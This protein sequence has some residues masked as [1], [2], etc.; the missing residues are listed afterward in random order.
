MSTPNIRFYSVE[1]ASLAC[2]A[3]ALFLAAGCPG[4]PD[5]VPCDTEAPGVL[6][7]IAGSGEN[8]HDHD[9]DT[10]ILPAL[11]ARFSLPQDTL[12][13][14][15][16]VL[17]ILDWNNHRLRALDPNGTIRW[18][19]GRGELGGS[20][21]D[22]ENGDFNHPTNIIFNQTG[23]RIIMAAWHNSKIREIDVAT[24]EIVDSC[25]DGKRA[26]FGDGGPALTASLD[27]PTSIALDPTGNLVI[28]DQANQVIRRIESDGS[29]QRIA[30]QCIVDS[31]P[32]RGPGRC[33]DG[34]APTQCPDGPNGPSGKFTCGDPA[35]FCGLPCTPGYSGDGML[36][37]EMRMNQPFGQSATPAGRLA[38]TA[39]GDLYFADTAN[40]LIR[41][42]DSD[43][44]VH[45]V[46]GQPPVGG[47]AQA[48]HSGDGGPASDALLNYPVDLAFSDSGV[49]YFTDANSHCV[50][51]I[52]PDGTISTAVGVCGVKGYEGDGGAADEALLNYPFGV[53]WAEGRLYVA[54]TGNSVIRA[55]HLP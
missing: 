23:T 11:E 46:A 52:E 43:G 19:A 26:Y 39:S 34:V 27:L 51:S 33:A 44:I 40:H 8:G 42:I 31:A 13:G 5:A 47:V 30:G 48:G 36:A 18:V 14:P 29:I 20:L 1:R 3:V 38:Y 6:C 15:D 41:R 10:M 24:G 49:L 53:A 2:I 28:M 37:T 50:R 35:E 22:P 21:D 17:Y 54:D 25:G 4:D 55:V 9:A 45:R 12:P 16:G 32:P 7:T